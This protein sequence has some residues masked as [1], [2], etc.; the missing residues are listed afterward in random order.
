[1][2]QNGARKVVHEILASVAQTVDRN[3]YV[4][5]P[6]I[7]FF[8]VSNSETRGHLKKVFCRTDEDTEYSPYIRNRNSSCKTVLISQ[9]IHSSVCGCVCMST[10]GCVYA[11]ARVVTVRMMVGKYSGARSGAIRVNLLPQYFGLRNDWR[12]RGGGGQWANGGGSF[13]A[14]CSVW[15]TDVYRC[16]GEEVCK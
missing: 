2:T 16:E 1:M 6:N 9:R 11:C 5:K 15:Q 13:C 7:P 8:L 12:I 14:N 10:L 3:R 4:R